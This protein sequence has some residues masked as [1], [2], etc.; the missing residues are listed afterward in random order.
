MRNGTN[1]KR[2]RLVEIQDGD[3]GSEK[4]K[5]EERASSDVRDRNS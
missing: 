5:V 3:E 4:E 2:E 1:R